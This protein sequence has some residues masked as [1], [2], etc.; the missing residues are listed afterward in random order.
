M[1]H[2]GR[3]IPVD[4]ANIVARLVFPD[5]LEGDASA[6]EDAMVFAAQKILDGPASA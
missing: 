1:T 4:A 3:D 5:F 2:A 6:L